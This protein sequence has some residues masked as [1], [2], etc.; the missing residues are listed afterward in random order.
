[1]PK[2]AANVFPEYFTLEEL[3]LYSGIAISTLRNWQRSGMPYYKLGRLVRIK[4]SDF[5]AWVVRF[6]VNGTPESDRRRTALAEAIKE[7][8]EP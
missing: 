6:Q 5:D 4:R 3:S 2:I 8:E 7:A 1:M